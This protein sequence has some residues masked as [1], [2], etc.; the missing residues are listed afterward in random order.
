MAE[1]S[2]SAVEGAVGCMMREY[3][4]IYSM[5]GTATAERFSLYPS[6]DW[7][8]ELRAHSGDVF[9]VRKLSLETGAEAAGMEGEHE[10]DTLETE[11]LSGIFKPVRSNE[12]LMEDGCGARVDFL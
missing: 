3:A 11:E 8:K 2:L 12:L 5:L 9:L 1:G 7:R 6:V 4:E 10:F